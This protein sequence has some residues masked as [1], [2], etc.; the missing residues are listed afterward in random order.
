MGVFNEKQGMFTFKLPSSSGMTVTQKALLEKQVPS[1][2]VECLFPAQTDVHSAPKEDLPHRW[3][4]PEYEPAFIM[5]KVTFRNNDIQ[6]FP[7]RREELS[8]RIC[9]PCHSPH[10]HL[11][12][13]HPYTH[14]QTQAYSLT[15]THSHSYTHFH[16]IQYI[17]GCGQ[18]IF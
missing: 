4:C 9:S 12:C 15:H 7:C 10:P 17:C 1:Q 18:Q 5:V 8:V 6:L 11:F 3:A 2:E 13:T 14:L 16:S